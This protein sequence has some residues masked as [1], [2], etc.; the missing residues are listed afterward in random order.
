MRLKFDADHH[1][2]LLK[3][4]GVRSLP[5]DVVVSSEGQV[6]V[7]T[8]GYQPKRTYVARLERLG[9]RLR[10]IPNEDPEPIVSGDAVPAKRENVVAPESAPLESLPGLDGFSP[11]SLYTWREWRK[12]KPEFTAYH[13]GITYRLATKEEL[14]QFTADP[15][16]YVPRLL[17]C[18]PVILLKTDRAVPGNTKFGAYYDGKLYLFQSDETRI[19]FKKSPV[20]YIKTRHV[21]NADEIELGETRQ[22]AKPAQPSDPVRQ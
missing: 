13:K 8:R 17:G 9:Q 15:E 10:P 3:R 22:S 18:D 11:V 7:Q 2:Q 19:E 6:L 4:F 20:R 5:A 14:N 21:L 1:P 12:G 16:K